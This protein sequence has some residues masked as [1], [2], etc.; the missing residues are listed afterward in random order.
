VRIA[1]EFC[2]ECGYAPK[3][4]VLAERLLEELEGVVSEV[5]L[6]PSSGGVFD[7][8]VDGELASGD[9]SA[10]VDEVAAAV[11]SAAA[12]SRR[13]RRRDRAPDAR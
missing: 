3:A 2:G 4:L 9:R 6:V 7:V 1:I 11:I 13:D 12:A 10:G 8:S 5:V